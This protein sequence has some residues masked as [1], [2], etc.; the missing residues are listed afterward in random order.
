MV[1]IN[2]LLIIPA[3]YA[4]MVVNTLLHEMGHAIVLWLFTK[5]PVNIYIGSYGD[6]NAYKFKINTT[7]C[8]TTICTGLHG[9]LY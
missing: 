1:L 5:Q 4:F 8:V 6:K 9:S 3:V 7:A 2:I